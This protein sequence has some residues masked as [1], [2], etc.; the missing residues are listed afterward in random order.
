[1]DGLGR[2]GR[3]AAGVVAAIGWTALAIQLPLSLAASHAA[4]RSTAGALVL[5]FSYFT[6]LTN[7]L[8]AVVMTGLALGR[9]MSHSLAGAATLNII[10]VGLVYS[11]VLRAIWNP[12]GWQKVADHLLHDVVPVAAV[13]VW[14]AFV[15]KGRLSFRNLP[16]WL[17]YPLAFLGWSLARGS[18]DGWYPYP[19]LDAG[20]LGLA[21]VLRNAL[22]VTA[23]F[24][25]LAALLVALDRRLGRGTAP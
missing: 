11:A 8:V 19:F 7:I 9:R 22:V 10:V 13:L 21:V 17:L 18:L 24:L 15:P 2:S 3:V 12:E 1:M 20:R 23:L 6:I 16:V 5:F 25:V 14:L 4:G